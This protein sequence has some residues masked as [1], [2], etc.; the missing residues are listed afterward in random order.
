[1]YLIFHYFISFFLEYSL[2]FGF[3]FLKPPSFRVK[4]P[5]NITLKVLINSLYEQILNYQLIKNRLYKKFQRHIKVQ[6]K[7]QTP[8]WSTIDVH[9][10]PG[11]VKCLRDCSKIRNWLSL[12]DYPNRGDEI[13]MSQPLFWF[14]ITLQNCPKTLKTLN[15]LFKKNK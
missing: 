2:T 10:A 15:K 9:G 1:M 11:C 4:M 3:E 6:D 5:S 8:I 14:S 13:G 7:L 12:G